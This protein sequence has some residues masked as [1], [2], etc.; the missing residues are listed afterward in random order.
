M[1][2]RRHSSMDYLARQRHILLDMHVPDWDERLLGKFDPR[3]FVDM[4]LEAGAD[5]VMVYCNSHVGLCYWPT[6]SGMMH[7]GLKGRDIVGEQVALLRERGIA[8]CAY[9]SGPLF[10]NWAYTR[11]PEWRVVPSSGG[12]MTGPGSRYGVLC[13]NRPGCVEFA[14]RQIDE[15]M[16]AYTF[17]AFFLDMVFWT[18][19]CVCED[20]QRRYADEEGSEIPTHLDWFSS[21][22]CQFQAA[23]ERWLTQAF[24]RLRERVKF[25]ADIPVF[26]NNCIVK[27]DWWAGTGVEIMLQQDLAGG[28]FSHRSVLPALSRLT[29]SVMQY[30]KAVSAYGGGASQLM[31]V[32]EQKA[33]A[34]AATAFGG[35]FMAIDA[36]APDGT[37][38]RP[39]YDRLR[40]V[41][42][43]MRPYEQ[44][45]GGKPLA[46]I[47]VYLSQ[48]SAVAFEDNGTRL[49]DLA[50]QLA[51]TRRASPH[52][53]ALEGAVK[54]LNQAHLPFGVLTKIDLARLDDFDVI[55]LPNVLRM[56]ADEISA[57]TQYVGRGG[58]LYASGYTSLVSVDGTFH[59]DFQLADVFGCH[60][61]GS[62]DVAI[63]YG[64]PVGDEAESWITPVK[65]FSRGEAGV[66]N[67]LFDAAITA[68]RVRADSTAE[69][70]ATTTLPFG[71][72]RGTRDDEAFASIH[73]SPP[74]EDTSRPAVTRHSFGAGEAIYAAFDL[75]AGDEH[76]LSSA[77]DFFVATVRSMLTRA[78]VFEAEAPSTVWVTAFDDLDRGERRVCFLNH[79]ESFPAYVVP[80]IDVRLSPPT[81]R[82]LVSL[83]KS[84]TGEPVPFEVAPEGIFTTVVRD[85]AVFEMLSATYAA[86]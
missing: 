25:H 32:A 10:N 3:A 84:A 80:R 31:P 60:F 5:A 43:E 27:F 41:F 77:P 9:Y 38:A 21:D 45:L 16:T 46:D 11:H 4:C 54:A 78:P 76:T 19:V 74:W 26:L 57:F 53:R 64:K 2:M 56:D 55:V 8:V 33:H 18:S 61:E 58:R 12:G 14:L 30:M 70:L 62:E 37:V 20:C 13:P 1:K 79:P 49:D 67:P 52:F 68:L 65:Y 23:R 39:T 17:D 40:E 36:I 29:P 82:R 72:G 22:W 24:V 81:G 50:E 34:L 69:V 48:Q 63:V 47:G 86:D 15:L 71:T 83:C 73:N 51:L 59:D 6:T 75:E 35:Q 28:D 7:R 85:L 42:D 66:N 44:Y